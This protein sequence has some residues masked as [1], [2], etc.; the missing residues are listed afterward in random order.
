M[1]FRHHSTDTWTVSRINLLWGVLG[2]LLAT[3]SPIRV[4]AQPA[5]MAPGQ[6]VFSS[7]LTE[8]VAQME[9]RDRLQVMEPETAPRVEDA[10]RMDLPAKLAAPLR[11]PVAEAAEVKSGA[12]V[13]APQTLSTSFDALSLTDSGFIPPD[14]MGAV[15]LHHFV[16]VINGSVAIYTKVGVR[17]SRVSLNSFFTAVIGGT[18]YPRNGSFDPHVIYDRRSGR[19]LAVALERGAVSGH[20]NDAILAVSAS[21]DPTGAW[22]KYLIPVGDPDSGGSAVFSDYDTLGTDENGVYVAVRMFGP[23][24][25]AK[26]AAVPKAQVLAAGTATVSVFTG[27][28]DMWATP[29]PAHNLDPVAAGGPAWFVASST[30]GYGDVN[31]RRLTWSGTTPTLDATAGGLTTPTYG[32]PVNAPASGSGTPINV[33]DDRLQMAVIRADS[34]WTCRSVGTDSAGGDAGPITRTA[35]EWLQLNVADVTPSL[36]QSGRVFDPATSN[37]RFYFYPS[38]M[39]NGQGHAVMGFSG[40]AATEFV[41][42]YFTGRLNG[43]AAGSMGSVTLIKA[44]AAAYQ[45]LDGSGR[46]RWGD[47]SYTSLDPADDMSLWTIQEYASAT[48]NLWGTWVAQALAPPPATPTA[49]SPPS[50]AVGQANISVAVAGI[51]VSGSGFFDP[52][53]GFPHRLAAAINGGG[54]TVNAATCAGPTSLTL[55]LTV[56]TGATPGARTITVTNPDGQAVTS[57]SGILTL[58]VPD[59][60]VEQPAGTDLTDGTGGVDFGTRTL[61]SSGLLKSFTI[62]N[63][64][65]ADLTGLVIT[66][67]GVNP[68][69]F[70]VDTTGTLVTVTPGGS[71][72]FAVTFNPGAV[73]ARSA[74]LHVASNDPDENPFDLALTGTGVAPELDVLGG[75]PLVSIPDGDPTPATT[76]GTDFGNQSVSSGTVVRTFTIENLGTA[77]LHVT[78]ISVSG[79]ETADFTV[80][81]LPLPATIVAGGST[82]F[83]VTFD[84]RAPGVRATT[85]SLANDD[86]NENPYDFV[87]QGTGID[88]TVTTAGNAIVVTDVSGNDDTLAVSEPSAGSIQFA[89]AGR[90]FSVDGGAARSGGS[91]VLDRTGVTQITVNAGAGA[92]VIDVGAF[93]GSLPSLTLNG[94]TGDD[95]VNFNGDLTFAADASL[96]VDLQ[97]DD[98][99]PGMDVVSLASNANLITSGNGA[100][101]VKC[102]RN[103]ILD[104]GSS[105]ETVGGGINLEAN[106]QTPPTADGFIGLSVNGRVRTTGQGNIVLAGRS[107]EDDGVFVQPGGLIESTASGANAGTIT[108][109]G[110]SGAVG[111]TANAAGF[112]LTSGAIET[113]DGAVSITGTGANATGSDNVGVLIA[114]FISPGAAHIRATGLGN[115]TIDGTALAGIAQGIRI[116]GVQPTAISTA[117]GTLTLT[118]TGVN[119]DGIGIS[120]ASSLSSRSGDLGFRADRIEIGGGT[121]SAGAG[122]VTFRPKTAG[123]PIDLGTETSGQLSL[124]DTELD[125]ITCGTLVIGDA[126]SGPITLSA[127]ISPANAAAV[128]LVSSMGIGNTYSAGPVM[129]VAS[130]T[131]SGNLAPGASPGRFTLDGNLNLAD[132]SAFTVEIGGTIPGTEYDQVRATGDVNIGANVTLTAR[133]YPA[134]G[135]Y[136]PA[137]GST[138]TIL[139]RAGG[140]GT[141]AGLPEAATVT[142]NGVALKISYVGGAGNDVTLFAPPPTAATLAYFRATTTGPGQVRLSWGTLVEVRTLGFHVDRATPAGGWQPVTTGILPAL[143]S[144]QRP[145]TYALPDESAPDAAGLRYRLV[146]V[147][148]SGRDEVVAEAVVTPAV[149]A[150]VSRGREGFTVAFRGQPGASVAVESAAAVTGPWTRQSTVQLDGQGAGSLTQGIGGG[151]PARYYRWAQE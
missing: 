37:P 74:A 88:Y 114:D 91:G 121:V 40:V 143:G 131:T 146:E 110:V 50:V 52:G 86:A 38:I 16:E 98:A 53:A 20:D 55:D 15:G 43:E 101:T 24:S 94:G 144:D 46:N 18:T 89:A 79:G 136:T 23:S 90:T 48:V 103:V 147:D 150:Q 39:P 83:T 124:T 25:F 123:T 67:D 65:T 45:R 93:T 21:P 115:I 56:A 35:C 3:L 2:A 58:T 22:N 42:A 108:I 41:G 77:D 119:A 100:I 116:N 132:H 6:V 47:Y 73:G 10:P 84:P 49:C 80:G 60:A 102:S 57:L 33:G 138:F 125:L 107:G 148:L 61:G 95:A 151:E 113:V 11:T 28:T 26:I 111:T 118:G 12:T 97:N 99:T 134:V 44:G 62:R 5:Q 105:L 106:Q 76:D 145:H 29:Q 59:I 137:A 120:G 17:L 7:P 87:I 27:I 36:V 64:G 9:A 8:T 96:D 135:G 112:S 71:S 75:S 149:T 14:T 141:F 4:S 34:L 13:E 133:S 82:T 139:S 126:T 109:T 142:V 104:S 129:T 30:A 31:Y 66:T 51:Q 122:T 117:S 92:D 140:S 19:W 1:N 127:A 70:T 72:T 69:D 130:L 85:L 78:G 32:Q 68:G 63:T 81:G 54:V 128:R